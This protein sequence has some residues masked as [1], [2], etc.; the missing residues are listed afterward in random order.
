MEA[1]PGVQRD[2]E[3]QASFVSDDLQNLKHHLLGIESALGAQADKI[4]SIDFPDSWSA[5]HHLAD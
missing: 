3:G 1:L 2:L 5:I 4:E